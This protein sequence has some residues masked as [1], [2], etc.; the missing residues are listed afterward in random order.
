M[1]FIA[2][3]AGVSPNVM[4]RLARDL[5][6]QSYKSFQEE[7]QRRLISAIPGNWR[8]RAEGLIGSS[9]ETGRFLSAETVD[10][11]IKNLQGA[12]KEENIA[13]VEQAANAI[14]EA[15]RM[16]VV[17]LRSLFPIAFYLHYVFR[18]FSDKSVLLTGLG[19]TF[20]DQLRSI[21]AEDVVVGFS[22]RPYAKDT[23]KAFEYARGNGAGTIVVTDSRVSPVIDQ[24]SINILVPTESKS[25]FPTLIPMFAVAQMLTTYI[26][27]RGSEDII[28]QIQR[29]EEQLGLF[30]TYVR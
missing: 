10:Q 22:C 19:G 12:L 21:T 30:D 28:K 23:V 8:S 11:E 15:R 25:F 16:Y 5:G 2:A 1:R 7:F 24:A 26:V 3:R 27:A 29:S 4:L 20:A 6:F 18:M 17:G 14:M 9:G 13:A